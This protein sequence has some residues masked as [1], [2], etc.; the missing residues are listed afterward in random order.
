ME[1]IL[2]AIKDRRK[3]NTSEEYMLIKTNYKA[4]KLF[5]QKL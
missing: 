3:K 1:V 5:V 4:K 2:S